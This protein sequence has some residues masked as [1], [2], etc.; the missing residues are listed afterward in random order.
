MVAKVFVINARTKMTQNTAVPVA[1][2]YFLQKT[3][4]P[5][6]FLT[7][8]VFIPRLKSKFN[9]YRGTKLFPNPD[10]FLNFA[11]KTKQK[12]VYFRK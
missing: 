7:Q 3:R 9:K 5:N 2:R 8:K 10:T 12:I 1:Y 11:Q 4:A 6:Y